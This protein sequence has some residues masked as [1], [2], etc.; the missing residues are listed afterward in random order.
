MQAHS[1]N[2][3]F[4]FRR[5]ELF[6]QGL[7]IA[8]LIAFA[9]ETLPGLSEQW[10]SILYWFE[11]ISVLVFTVEYLLRLILF[12]PRGAYLMSFWGIIDLLAILPF[13][14][15]FAVDGRTIRSIRL[16]RLFRILKLVRYS[17]AFNRYKRAYLIVKEELV[18]F[19]VSALIILYISGVGIYYFE[20]EAQ[21]ELFA[22][23]FHSL[24]WGI[25]TLTTVGFGDVYPITVGGKV[26]TFLILVVGLG[27]V[28]VPSGLFA[29]AL[30]KARNEEDD[31]SDA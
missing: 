4:E 30:S 8:N 22:S 1:I 31:E 26:F 12:K 16:L 5:G 27:V 25:V 23:V 13:Y 19:G 15:S 3:Q 2:N 14:L 18:L 28:A 11:L 10:I 7:I 17:K 24:W 29:S 20:H 21:P 9:I 6:I